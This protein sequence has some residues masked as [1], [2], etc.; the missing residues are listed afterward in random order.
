MDCVGIDN[1]GRAGL[2]YTRFYD[3]QPWVWG[4]YV[5]LLGAVSAVLTE[6]VDKHVTRV[7]MRLA[8]KLPPPDGKPAPPSDATGGESVRLLAGSRL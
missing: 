7:L 1:E 2:T 5:V 4:L 6:F 8:P 3:F